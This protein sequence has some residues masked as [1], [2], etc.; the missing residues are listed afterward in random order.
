M[1]R[2]KTYSFLALAIVTASLAAI[3][4]AVRC[5][6]PATLYSSWP[7]VALWWG[8]ALL[9]LAS[10]IR[11]HLK[12]H[13]AVFSIHISLLVILLGAFVTWLSAETGSVKLTYG[14]A[15]KSFTNETGVRRQLPYELKADT[16]IVDTYPGTSA[17]M[18]FHA[19]LT[20]GAEKL[21]LS[22]N[23]TAGAEGY[24]FLLKSIDHENH[25]VTLSVSQDPIGTSISYTGYVLLG[26][27]F[28][29]FFFARGTQFR[30]SLRRITAAFALLLCAGLTVSA[31]EAPKTVSP[32]F[33]RCF[34]KMPVYH[35]DRITPMTTLACDFTRQLAGAANVEGLTPD[36]VFAG[37]LFHFSDW[38]ER[39]V[40]KVSGRTAQ[41]LGID[42]RRASYVDFFNASAN[43]RIDLDH[44]SG[45]SREVREDI[46]R[47]ESVN[48]LVSGEMLRIFPVSGERGVVW[49]SPAGNDVPVS[50][51]EE[52]WMFVR[53]SLGLI[54]E[55]VQTRRYADAALIV[56]KIKAYQKKM[57]P[58]GSLPTEGQ[59]RVERVYVSRLRD[60]LPWGGVIAV[61]G[62]VGCFV[63]MRRRQRRLTGIVFGIVSMAVFLYITVCISLRWICTGHV[64]LSDGYETMQ[65]MAWCASLAAMLSAWRTVMLRLLVCAGAVMVAGLCM[66]VA[67]MSGG[68]ATLTPLMPVLASPWLSVHVVLVMLAYTLFALMAVAGVAGLCSKNETRSRLADFARVLTAPAVFLLA[69]GIFVGAVWANVSWGRYWGW[70]PKEVWA[71]VTML[72]YTF[73]LHS[74]LISSLARP[75]PYLIYSAA[76]FLTVLFTYFGVNFLMGGLHSYA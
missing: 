25:T 33:A 74:R 4:I 68:A 9:S 36:E 20:A 49:I 70:D 48:M 63:A 21:T 58:E 5:G 51:S 16:V 60:C 52:E 64:P 7:M 11:A 2:L 54:N 55:M 44:T 72:V 71:L 76:A 42:G 10:I 53:K 23:N 14:I 40:I 28:I 69:A 62:L 46:A 43:G 13:P 57:L 45:L 27:S 18:D 35:N 75:K 31:A 34:G 47:F 56:D 39:R 73:P 8:T 50:L 1:H 61:A 32:A 59:M 15:T 41:L 37:F 67:G 3:S 65:F 24:R 26:L 38:K 12:R 22:M 29:L 17:A 6:A 66:L 30:A 19:R